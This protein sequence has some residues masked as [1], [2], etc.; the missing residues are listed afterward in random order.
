MKRINVN[1]FNGR[2]FGGFF[3]KAIAIGGLIRRG[4]IS[5]TTHVEI[6]F[7]DGVIW[8]GVN[9]RWSFSSREASRDGEAGTG[10]SVIDYTQIGHWCCYSFMVSD[11]NYRKVFRSC[12]AINGKKYDR[13]AILGFTFFWRWFLPKAIPAYHSKDEFIC[14]E[15]VYQV[16]IGILWNQVKNLIPSPYKLKSMMGT[17][18]TQPIK[19]DRR[20]IM[21]HTKSLD[22]SKQAR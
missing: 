16:G 3:S 14:S 4:K 1:Y 22:L 12:K 18:N 7:A 8:N 17:R 5:N 20:G 10:F 15:A 21:I 2:K 9:D 13:K 19:L 6:Q 11:K